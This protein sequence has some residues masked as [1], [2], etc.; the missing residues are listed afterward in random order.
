MEIP[1]YY[2]LRS[3]HTSNNIGGGVCVFYSTYLPLRV[4]NITYLSE[5]ITFEISI[6]NKVFHF[7]HLY[8]SPSQTQDKFQ[9]FKSYLKL[10]LDALLC[11]DPFVTAMIADFNTNS[12]DWC[13]NL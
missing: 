10:H 7:I 11:G 2:L 6:G 12:K 8:R 3:D 9:T 1:G 4:L 13:S 5:C